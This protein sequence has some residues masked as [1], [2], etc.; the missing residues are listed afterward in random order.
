MPCYLVIEGWGLETHNQIM[1]IDPGTDEATAGGCG[2]PLKY[3][4]MPDEVGVLPASMG[5]EPVEESEDTTTSCSSDDDT[6]CYDLPPPFGRK[7][8]FYKICW[9]WE[10]T[11]DW[12]MNMFR[13]NVEVDGDF[14]LCIPGDGNCNI[15]GAGEVSGG[16]S[17][18]AEAESEYTEM[19]QEQRDAETGLY[20]TFSPNR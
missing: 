10:P 1:V 8:S 4:V 7:G 5:F 16:Q 9:A 3:T 19:R 18:A 13:F 6:S 14:V 20:L 12:P 2:D 15:D 11:G 17:D